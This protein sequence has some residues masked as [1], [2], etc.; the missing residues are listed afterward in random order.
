MNKTFFFR[1]IITMVITMGLATVGKAE[2]SGA[3]NVDGIAYF[4]WNIDGNGTLHV[5]PLEASTSHFDKSPFYKYRKQIK[6]VII[7][8]DFYC[9]E[10]FKVVGD[11]LF[12]GLDRLESVTFSNSVRSI[13]ESAFEGCT[14]LKEITIPSTVENIGRNALKGCSSLVSVSLPFLG[15]DGAIWVDQTD[16]NDLSW[17]F[18]T[19]TGKEYYNVSHKIG[20]KTM[21]FS[22]PV[23]LKS[24]SVNGGILC[25]DA[26]SD[27][28]SI[29]NIILGKTAKSVPS[30]L[31]AGYYGILYS[32]K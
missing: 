24:L 11:N 14:A 23:S 19:S 5:I 10:G 25:S 29:E 2:E 18:G 20:K 7:E 26:F 31:V 8:D 3:C 30:A 13:G 9:E 15:F 1:M 17:I 27:C 21:S 28:S 22:V 6:N 32:G 16:K 12:K 4:I